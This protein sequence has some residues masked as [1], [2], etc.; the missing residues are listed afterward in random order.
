[1]QKGDEL[2]TED[3]FIPQLGQTVEDVVLISWLVDDGVKVDFG[4]PVLE[5]ETDKAVF[6]VEA[7][8]KGFLY[9]GI[10]EVGETVPVL[11]VVA[12]IGKKGEGFSPSREMLSIS[13]GDEDLKT[14]ENA[15]SGKSE[16]KLPLG[17]T[18]MSE[19]EKIFSSPRARKL[20]DEKQVDLSHVSPTGGKGLRVVEQDVLDYLDQKLKATPIASAMAQKMGL[21]ITSLKGSGPNGTVVKSDV[22]DAIKEMLNKMKSSSQSSLTSLDHVEADIINRIPL[23]SI[24]KKIFDHMGLSVHTTAR[25][26]LVTEAD[27]TDLVAIRD[28]FQNQ[29]FEKWGFTPGYNDFL[30]FIVAQTLGELP[31]MNSRLSQDGKSIEILRNVNL[32]IAVDTDRGLIVPVIKNADQKNLREIGI[33]L[34]ELVD[35]AKSGHSLPED[36]HA[37]TFTITNLGPFDVDAF[38]PVINLPEAAILGIGRIRDKVVPFKGEI[39]IRKM[40]TLSLVFDHRLV[41]GAPA[42][43]FLQNIK[44]KVEDPLLMLG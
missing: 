37:G 18:Q 12:T 5:V 42:A 6:N 44:Q 30:G 36:L 39:K 17:G 31:Y 26:T 15:R 24:K 22:E 2:M 11:T 20:A 3:L 38:T 41:D 23:K 25:V 34:R 43:R 33:T 16:Q 7:N 8:A 40:L 13:T 21:D 29:V 14:Q 10:Y 32:G 35:R 19:R 27:A 1:L 4:D 9:K 28:R